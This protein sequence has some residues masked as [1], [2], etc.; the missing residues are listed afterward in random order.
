[1]SIALSLPPSCPPAPPAPPAVPTLVVRCSVSLRALIDLTLLSTPSR[2]RGIGRYAAD[3]ACALQAVAPGHPPVSIAAVERFGW[4]GGAAIADD[5]CAAVRRILVDPR[6]FSHAQ[7]AY[8]VR[9][10]LASIVRRSGADVVHSPHPDATPI[11]RLG[12]PRIVT[13][14]DLISLRAPDHYAGWRDGWRWGR[15]RL[16]A[17]RYGSADHI[18]AVSETTAA[19]L[20][21]ILHA[22]AQKITVV[23]HGV[24]TR[25]FAP[26]AQPGDG[27]AR[28]RYGL[29]G[30]RYLLFVGAA[31]W[32]KNAAGMMAALR[33]VLQRRSTEDLVL[34]WAGRIDA[35]DRVRLDAVITAS[36]V[37]AG[38]KLLG[39]VP[40]PDLA[41]LMRGALALLFVSRIEGFGY[42]LVEAMAS[43]CPVVGSNRPATIE[44]SGGAVLLVDPDRPG[45]IADAIAT[46]ADD[47][48]ERRRLAARGLARSR[49]FSLAAMAERTADVYRHVAARGGR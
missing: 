18:I 39:Y 15:R 47:A 13:C 8:R 19:D 2:A 30:R 25:R 12:C 43:G 36:G 28:Q 6:R 26:D 31:D 1:M 7:W 41:A 29:E 3:L 21:A 4:S 34:V 5:L 44:M 22:P 9:L 17:R 37:A 23:H 27:P 32:R 14:H 10:R 45:E 48:A 33:I 11:G 49:A 42:P 40:D 24:D 38:V 16:D 35:D 46:L 20:V